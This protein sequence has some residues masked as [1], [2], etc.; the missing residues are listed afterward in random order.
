MFESRSTSPEVRNQKNYPAAE[1]AP[2]SE[3][4]NPE[5]AARGFKNLFNKV[6]KNASER[7]PI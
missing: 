7:L 3:F 2:F 6:V 4:A 1:Q 5:Q